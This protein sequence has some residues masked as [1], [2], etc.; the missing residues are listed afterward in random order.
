VQ[1]GDRGPQ[2]KSVNNNLFCIGLVQRDVGN[3]AYF[4]A[5]TAKAVRIFQK[6]IGYQV[7][8]IAT[9]KVQARLISACHGGVVVR[10]TTRRG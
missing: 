9:G 1:Q 4:S 2:V 10:D 7:T 3:S 5:R 8:G 6:S